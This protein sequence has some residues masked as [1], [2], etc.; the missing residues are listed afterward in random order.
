[1]FYVFPF[2][3]LREKIIGFFDWVSDKIGRLMPVGYSYDSLH[4]ANGT[5]VTIN[6]ETGDVHVALS[7]KGRLVVGG[8]VFFSCDGMEL[9]MLSSKTITLVKGTGQKKNEDSDDLVDMDNYPEP[10]D[11]TYV[12]FP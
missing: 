10:W 11:R 6:Q 5:R 7:E 3:Y 4:T 8:P 12:N 2:V 1:M 9:Q